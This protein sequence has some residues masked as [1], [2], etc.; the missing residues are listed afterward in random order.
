MLNK[1]A[2]ATSDDLKVGERV[3]T[4]GADNPDGSVTATNIQLNPSQLTPSR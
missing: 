1:A 2:P 3:V 4:F